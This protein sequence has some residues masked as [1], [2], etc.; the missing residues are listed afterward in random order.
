MLIPIPR[1]N[2]PNVGKSICK[3]P[4]GNIIRFML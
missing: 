3:N 1:I 4:Y 2:L